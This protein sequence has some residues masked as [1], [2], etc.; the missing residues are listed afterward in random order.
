MYNLQ[1]HEW[2]PFDVPVQPT[3]KDAKV[4]AEKKAALLAGSQEPDLKWH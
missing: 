1:R 2:M 4:Y 3:L